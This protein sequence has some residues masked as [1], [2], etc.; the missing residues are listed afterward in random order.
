[1]RRAMFANPS[2]NRWESMSNGTCPSC[3]AGDLIKISMAVGGRDLAFS[4]CHHCEAK[5]WYRDGEEVPLASVIGLVVE[6]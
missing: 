5:W 1:V 4:T 3:H 6:K 2:P